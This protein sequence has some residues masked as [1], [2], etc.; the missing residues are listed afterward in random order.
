MFEAIP[1]CAA[2]HH[3]TP[4]EVVK[5]GMSTYY[6]Y[7]YLIIYYYDDQM[8]LGPSIFQIEPV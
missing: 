4:Q 5:M 2:E 1:R 3:K 8:Y 6:Y 7:I